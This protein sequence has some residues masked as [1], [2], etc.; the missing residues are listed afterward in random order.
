MSEQELYDDEGGAELPQQVGNGPSGKQPP[1]KMENVTAL[2]QNPRTRRVVI[3]TVAA[4]AIVGAI[5]II[6][7]VSKNRQTAPAPPAALTGVSVGQ[8]PSSLDDKQNAA[9]AQSRE[10]QEIMAKS[11]AQRA[12]EAAQNGQSTQPLAATVEAALQPNQTPAEREEAEAKARKEK[13]EADAVATAQRQAMELAQRQGA[14]QQAGNVQVAQQPDPAQQQMMQTAAQAIQALAA[15]RGRGAAVYAMSDSTQAPVATQV[16]AG[17][18]TRVGATSQQVSAQQAAP[19]QLTLIGAGSIEAARIDTGV[20]T[21][22]GGDFGATLLTGRYAG[23]KIIGTVQRRGETAAMT[24]RTIAFPD[25]GVS[26]PATCSILDAET[27]EGGT[28]SDVDRKLLVKYGIKPI[29]AGF[30]AVADYLKNSGTTVVVNG[31]TTVTS[32]PEL[33][34]KKAAQIVGG[35]AAQQVNTDANALDTTP[36]VRVRRNTV[37][38][39]FFTQDVI[40]TP[41]TR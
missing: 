19:P 32:S 21:D 3:A 27:G 18:Y 4:V 14:V 16:S 35:S 31:Q 6:S 15:N 23:A 36:T 26:I 24:C 39:V 40:Y 7:I 29:A 12:S 1:G 38:G 20:N 10:Y 28:A 8:A 2:T 11:G 17:G 30:A 37:V 41:K 34:G 5:T 22:V 9:L 25:Q 13:A 33:T